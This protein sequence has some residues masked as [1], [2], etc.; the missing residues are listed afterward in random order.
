MIVRLSVMVE[1]ERETQFLVFANA[2]ATTQ[3][4]KSVIKTAETQ[5]LNLDLLRA[6]QSNLQLTTKHKLSIWHKLQ[7]CTELLTVL[8]LLNRCLLGLQGML[9]AMGRLHCFRKLLISQTIH[10]RIQLENLKDDCKQHCSWATKFQIQPTA[11]S[12]KIRFCF[13]YQ[14]RTTTQST[15][16]TLCSTQIPT[17]ITV[18]LSI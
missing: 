5:H 16:R 9:A 1:M 14:T 18:R 8:A 12:S 6:L 2:K 11:S 7:M 3:Q 17:S 4:I 13:R 10:R 15:W